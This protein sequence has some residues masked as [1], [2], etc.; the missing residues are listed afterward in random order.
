MSILFWVYLLEVVAIMVITFLMVYRYMRKGVQ[1]FVYFSVYV[2][3][4]L[5]FVIL[6]TLPFDIYTTSTFREDSPS[7]TMQ[8]YRDFTQW[9]WKISY[10]MT[11]VLT[12]FIF[13]FFMVYVVRGEFSIGRKL[14]MTC[15]YN[16]VSYI[17]YLVLIAI[18]IPVVFVLINKNRK[19]SE[20]VGIFDVC[21][22][23]STVYGLLLIVFLM[24][25]GMVAFPQSLWKRSSY[26]SRIKYLLYHI[27]IIE[28]KLNDLRIELSIVIKDLESLTVGNDLIPYLDTIKAE[29]K[30]FTTNNPKFE[31]E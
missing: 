9:N 14:L 24:S 16:L 6:A 27:S 26:R 7:D 22:I 18:L 11:F 3:W 20:K 12:W 8:F 21:Y 25:Y 30:Y 23:L 10:L 29:I 4:I 19:K 15:L 28:E 13:P 1:I 2:G 5:G 17:I 31:E